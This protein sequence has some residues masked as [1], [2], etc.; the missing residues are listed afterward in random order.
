MN[1]SFFNSFFER[2]VHPRRGL[3]AFEWVIMIYMLIKKTECPKIRGF[4][5]KNVPYTWMYDNCG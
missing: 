1:K 3:M 2:D 4:I 5:V